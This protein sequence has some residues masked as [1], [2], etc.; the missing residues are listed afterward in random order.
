MQLICALFMISFL[1]LHREKIRLNLHTLYTFF[2][3]IFEIENITA[4][5]KT[6][7]HWYDAIVISLTSHMS[8]L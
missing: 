5:C 6:N 2:G 4:H 8:C 7:K 1:I 3:D